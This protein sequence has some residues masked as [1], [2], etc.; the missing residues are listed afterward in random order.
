MARQKRAIVDRL[1][2]FIDIS[3]ETGCW[4]W[5]GSVQAGRGAGYGRLTVDGGRK[6]A[7]RVSYEHLVEPIPAGLQLDHLCTVR[8]CI[9]PDHLEP[10]TQQ[11]NLRRSPCHISV[12][13]AAKTH[14]AQGHEYTPENTYI[15][16]GKGKTQRNCRS[17]NSAYSAKRRGD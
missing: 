2:E 8:N 16:V 1:A 3:A 17:C 11:E 9:N 5:T 15:W 14:C 13:N 12:L 10:V 4:L 6:L 7:H